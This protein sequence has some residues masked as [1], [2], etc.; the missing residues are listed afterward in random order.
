MCSP[1]SST[2]GFSNLSL[3]AF[4]SGV[5]S[6]TRF[7]GTSNGTK[8]DFGAFLPEIYT[9]EVSCSYEAASY[10]GGGGGVFLISF[11]ASFSLANLAAA[12]AFNFLIKSEA[13][14]FTG[15]AAT[16]GAGAFILISAFGASTTGAV[17]TA[18]AGSA[19]ASTKAYG[20]ADFLSSAFY[21]S[22]VTVKS[23]AEAS[24]SSFL[25]ALSEVFDSASVFLV[26]LSTA[27]AFLFS[28]TV[29]G[30]GVYKVPLSSAAFSNGD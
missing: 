13:L 3:A 24:I 4:S 5:I 8:L 18:A 7:F 9:G 30:V 12:L 14:D 21:L 2:V 29:S 28:L 15:A 10:T 1:F 22:S 17:S 16:T 23:N 19:L 6:L 27:S 20:A 26:Y 25:P 11:S